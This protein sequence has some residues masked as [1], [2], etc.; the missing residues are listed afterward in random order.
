MLIFNHRLNRNHTTETITIEFHFS[1][2][3]SSIERLHCVML[4]NS[5]EQNT[6][7]VGKWLFIIIFALNFYTNGTN[8]VETVVNYSY[9]GSI[10]NKDWLAYRF[11][12]GKFYATYLLP[13]YLPLLFIVPMFW[14]R[15]KA[16]P[17]SF[18]LIFL[19][20]EIRIFI[21]TAIYFVPKIQL[22]LQ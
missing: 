9:W 5:Y 4:L 11:S 13:A 6:R 16:I 20:A 22:P 10:G 2:Y 7:L 18:I 14:L 12:N 1:N 8:Y 17:K 15:P 3:S 19:M 21:T